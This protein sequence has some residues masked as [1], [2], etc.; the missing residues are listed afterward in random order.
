M[1]GLVGGFLVGH[2]LSQMFVISD[3]ARVTS[4]TAVSVLLAFT[5]PL[6]LG[7]VLGAYLAGRLTRPTPAPHVGSPSDHVSADGR[8]SGRGDAFGDWT[9]MALLLG[10]VAVDDEAVWELAGLVETPLRQKLETALRLRS[11]VVD[12]TSDDRTAILRALEDAPDSL[13]GVRELLV[14]DERWR[15]SLTDLRQV[16]PASSPLSPPDEWTTARSVA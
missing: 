2:L 10:G 15:E 3:G 12:V 1:L 14:T 13:M 11:G 7:T 16:R 9:G 8:P 6:T 4:E 5:V